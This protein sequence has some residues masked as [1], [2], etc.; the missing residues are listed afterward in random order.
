MPALDEYP[1]SVVTA[2]EAETE[3]LGRRLGT[4]LRG[5]EVVLL[6]GA[7]GTGKTCFARGLCRGL[8][9]A[10]EVVSPTFTLVNTYPGSPTVHHLDFY[11]IGRDTPLEDIGVMEVL[12]EVEDGQA[13]LVAEWPDPLLPELRGM[14]PIYSWLGQAVPVVGE[15]S[16]RLRGDDPDTVKIANALQ[17][18]RVKG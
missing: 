15:R 9:I 13:V 12:D 18:K 14:G 16:W 7:L 6:H 4:L 10:D 5:G 1:W 11:R 3:D 8:G 17:L 2:S